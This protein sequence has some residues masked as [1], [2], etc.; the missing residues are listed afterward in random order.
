MFFFII[1]HPISITP[2]IYTQDTLTEDLCIMTQIEKYANSRNK[3]E[4]KRALLWLTTFGIQSV[5]NLKPSE[6]FFAIIKRHIEGECDINQIHLD[7]R[8][9]YHQAHRKSNSG[10]LGHHEEADKVS[11]RIMELLEECKCSLT[12]EDFRPCYTPRV[13]SSLT[14]WTV[15]SPRNGKSTMITCRAPTACIAIANSSPNC[16]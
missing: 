16:S 11:V 3:E 12:V 4:K 2:I 7:T 5:V 10:N 8:E 1:L 14:I 9:Y 15:F 13:T 6:D